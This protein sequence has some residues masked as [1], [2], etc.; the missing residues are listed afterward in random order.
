MKKAVALNR[1]RGF[2]VGNSGLSISHLQYADD[3]LCI[4]EASIEN[5][6]SLKAILRGFQ[7]VSGLKVNFWKSNLMSVNVSDDFMRVA[8]V[9]LNC[10]IG[11]IPFKYL[12]LPVGASPRRASTW[13]PLLDSLKKRLGAWGN[14]YVSLAGRIILLNSVL[15]A[16]PIFYLSYMKMPI[17]VWKTI[18]RLQREFLWG[19]RRGKN[20]IPWVK[21]DVVCLPKRMGGLGVR[22][23]R[24][25]N[26]SLLTK[27]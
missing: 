2:R 1:F 7:L 9:F 14:K 25:V 10:R 15:N 6:W 27:W 20:R 17:Q 3:T 4:R 18:R 13:E 19:G 8:F 16:I 22:D 24:V 12:G 26:I 23:V 5:L 11:S 21:W